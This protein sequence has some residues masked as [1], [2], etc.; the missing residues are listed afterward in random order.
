MVN[1]AAFSLLT[2]PF[3]LVY[4]CLIVVQGHFKAVSWEIWLIAIYRKLRRKIDTNFLSVCC[5][6]L[7]LTGKLEVG[8]GNNVTPEC[9]HFL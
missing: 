2:V 3:F 9:T 1:F 5:V 8:A 7:H 6:M 4:C